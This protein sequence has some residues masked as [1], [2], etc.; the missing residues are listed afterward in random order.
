M[1]KIIESRSCTDYAMKANWKEGINGVY[2]GS[3][4]RTKRE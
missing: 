1:K 4:T 2:T 3:R